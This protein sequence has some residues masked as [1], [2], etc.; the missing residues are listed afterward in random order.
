MRFTK[1]H[2]KKTWPGLELIPLNPKSSM[3]YTALE[4]VSVN[5]YNIIRILIV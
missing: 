1:E 4:V 5:F 2:N 3:S